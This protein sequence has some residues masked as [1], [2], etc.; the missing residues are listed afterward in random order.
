[1]WSYTA[2]ESSTDCDVA[3]LQDACFD[4][5]LQVGSD[6]GWWSSDEI[7]GM[8]GTTYRSEGPPPEC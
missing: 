5:R 2:D 6:S 4:E 3:V 1:M 8:L 7:V